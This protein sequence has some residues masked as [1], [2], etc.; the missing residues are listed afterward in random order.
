VAAAAITKASRPINRKLAITCS[1]VPTDK[2]SENNSNAIRIP[3]I[4]SVYR[5]A[6]MFRAKYPIAMPH[7]MVRKIE[8]M[9][10]QPFYNLDQFVANSDFI[11]LR[12]IDNPSKSVGYNHDR[13]IVGRCQIQVL[14][15]LIGNVASFIDA[16][17]KG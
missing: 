16:E 4:F 2:P 9:V 3:M 8:S 11:P 5:V 14:H 1:F 7:V 15:Q 17:S 6:G 10:L 12:S 13:Q